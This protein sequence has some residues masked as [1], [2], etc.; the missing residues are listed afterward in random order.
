MN[1]LM[2]PT[3]GLATPRP[4]PDRMQCALSA[5]DQITRNQWKPWRDSIRISK[6][7]KC[8]NRY[9]TIPSRMNSLI[10]YC[11]TLFYRLIT[12]WIAF[13]RFNNNVKLDRT[14]SEPQLVKYYT[15][16]IHF[17]I[18]TLTMTSA[19]YKIRWGQ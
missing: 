7:R 17:A 15:M 13:K 6:I 10:R 18:T 3:P 14:T 2:Q 1:I 12:G 19:A 5:T 11:V 8:Q 9:K 4:Q 16:L